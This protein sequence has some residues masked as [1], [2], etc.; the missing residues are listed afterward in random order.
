VVS[1][2]AEPPDSIFTL[3]VRPFSWDLSTQSELKY[4]VNTNRC[5][6]KSC[7]C[8]DFFVGFYALAVAKTEKI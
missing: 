4:S 1:E 7:I 3:C 2:G 6:L 5:A 8:L